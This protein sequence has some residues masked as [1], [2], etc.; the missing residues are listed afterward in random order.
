[1]H[2]LPELTVRVRPQIYHLTN[3]THVSK[4]VL[5]TVNQ[6]RR[7][8]HLAITGDDG[9]GRSTQPMSTTQV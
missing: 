6:G 5:R 1:M 4:I 9:G 7:Y 2:A 3:D 8:P